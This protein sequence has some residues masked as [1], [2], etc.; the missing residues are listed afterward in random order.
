MYIYFFVILKL[1][2][3]HILFNTQSK[4]ERRF[5]ELQPNTVQFWAVSFINY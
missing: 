4:F 3:D 2:Y 1:F 5:R